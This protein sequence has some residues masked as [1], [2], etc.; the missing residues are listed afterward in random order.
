MPAHIPPARGLLR[1]ALKLLTECDV[2]Q[3][4]VKLLSGQASGCGRWYLGIDPN[5]RSTGYVVLNKSGRA[6][7]WGSVQVSRGRSVI[8]GANLVASQLCALRESMDVSSAHDERESGFGDA[9]Q[10][11]HSNSS[12]WVVGIEDFMKTFVAGRFQTRSLFAL[13]QFNGIV[14]Y[15]CTRTFGGRSGESELLEPLLLHPT[16]VRSAF[17]LRKTEAV[18]D[19]KRVVFEFAQRREPRLSFCDPASG[20]AMGEWKLT[21]KGELASDNFDVTDAWLIAYYTR[22]V[23]FAEVMTACP[24]LRDDFCSRLETL[25]QAGL[26]VRQDEAAR[27]PERVLH[28]ALVYWLVEQSEAEAVAQAAEA[29]RDVQDI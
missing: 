2:Q 15:E 17:V 12:D 28:E 7:R 26:G 9:A 27:N 25:R 22:L 8:S 10:G 29:E 14:A 16:R 23:H 18:P 3:H 11:A 19:V 20:G 1:K 13:A 4:A 21:R 5:L 6:V 24:A